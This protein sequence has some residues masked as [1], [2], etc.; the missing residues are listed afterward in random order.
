MMVLL[1]HSNEW[2]AYIELSST[3]Y[4]IPVSVDV[5]CAIHDWCFGHV[6]WRFLL[7]RKESTGICI[8]QL[9]MAEG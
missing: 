1:C 2:I 4:H 5:F 9:S 8:F 7:G 3:M 6:A